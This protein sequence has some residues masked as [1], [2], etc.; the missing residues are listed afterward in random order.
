MNMHTHIYMFTH[1][2][3]SPPP[4]TPPFKRKELINLSK[5]NEGDIWEGLKG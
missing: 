1:K 3:P 4:Q 5:S 2:T